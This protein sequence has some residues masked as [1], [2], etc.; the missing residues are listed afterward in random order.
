MPLSAQA[1]GFLE[2]RQVRRGP[3]ILYYPGMEIDLAGR[4]ARVVSAVN[5]PD[6]SHVILEIVYDD[7]PEGIVRMV[8]VNILEY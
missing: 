3:N 8:D 2:G 5:D 7:D 6:G 1:I 4:C